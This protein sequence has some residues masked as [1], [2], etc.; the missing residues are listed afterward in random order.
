MAEKERWQ[1]VHGER[2]VYIDI[3]LHE[4]ARGHHGGGAVSTNTEPAEQ[5]AL[6]QTAE[7]AKR[8]R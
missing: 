4:T 3:R 1:N 2:G 8:G 5:A 7:R 6:R